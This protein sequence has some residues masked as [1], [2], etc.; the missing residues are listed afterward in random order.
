MKLTWSHCSW[1]HSLHF[2][3]SSSTSASRDSP[4]FL[5]YLDLPNAPLRLRFSSSA[6]ASWCWPK[7]SPGARHA[8]LWPASQRREAA[9]CRCSNA[10]ASSGYLH[11]TIHTHSADRM[12]DVEQ[13]CWGRTGNAVVGQHPQRP[14]RSATRPLRRRRC[15]CAASTPAPRHPALCRPRTRRRRAAQ[16]YAAGRHLRA[17]QRPINP[18]KIVEL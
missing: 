12:S 6:C 13:R 14:S 18:C 5:R 4:A 1:S 7:D 8:I 17:N 16:P 3:H 9:M 2:F 15:T 11:S 10:R